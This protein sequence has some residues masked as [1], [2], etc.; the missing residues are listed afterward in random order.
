MHDKCQQ[1]RTPTHAED[2][3][4]PHSEKTKEQRGAKSSHDEFRNECAQSSTDANEN[5]RMKEHKT[6]SRCAPKHDFLA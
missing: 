2:N 4:E 3:K 5:T 6:K 1:Q